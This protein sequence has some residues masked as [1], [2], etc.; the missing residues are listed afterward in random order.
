MLLLQVLTVQTLILRLMLILLLLLLILL[1]LTKLR[2]LTKPRLLLMVSTFYC[3][4]SHVFLFAN[5]VIFK[6][7][8]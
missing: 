6:F 7:Q 5:F 1:L 2:L 4:Y 3:I 8:F